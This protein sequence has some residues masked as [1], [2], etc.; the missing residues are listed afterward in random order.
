MVSMCSPVSGIPP[1]LVVDGSEAV[2]LVLLL[3]ESAVAVAVA[4]SAELP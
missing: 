3:L 1:V 4:S 2:F